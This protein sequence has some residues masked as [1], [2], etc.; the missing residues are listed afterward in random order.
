MNIESSKPQVSLPFV[1]VDVLP[2]PKDSVVLLGQEITEV[3]YENKLMNEHVYYHLFNNS[4]WKY[5]ILYQLWS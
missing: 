4:E 5:D 1:V 2:T 3:R